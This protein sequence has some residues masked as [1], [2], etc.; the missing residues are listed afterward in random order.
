MDSKARGNS[1]IA[2]NNY[3]LNVKMH[4]RFD[5]EVVDSLTGKVKETAQAENVICAALW[6][7]M[8]TPTTFFYYIHYGTGSGTPATTDTSLFTFL[9][10]IYI[11][12]TNDQYKY[13]SVNGVLSLTRKVQI[14][15]SVAV[16]STITEI[17]IAYGSSANNLCTHAMIKDMNGNQI[18]IAKTSTDII[19]VYATIFA[20]I[21]ATGYDNGKLKFTITNN[22]KYF[23]KG[24]N[25]FSWLL[26]GD[27]AGGNRGVLLND[28]GGNSGIALDSS[29]GRTLSGATTTYDATNKKCIITM[30]RLAADKMN[31][32]SG[33]M[34]LQVV[35]SY[36]TG[37]ITRY[38]PVIRLDTEGSWYPETVIQGEAV[39]TGDGITTDFATKFNYAENATVYVNG[40]ADSNVSVQ[41]IPHKIVTPELGFDAISFESVTGSGYISPRIHI[42]YMNSNDGTVSRLESQSIYYNRLYEYGISKFSL[43]GAIVECSDDQV[44]WTEIARNNS[45]SWIVVTVPEVNRHSKYWRLTSIFER[46]YYDIDGMIFATAPPTTNIHFSV[47]PASG[48]VITADYHTPVIAKDVN[49]VFDLTVT[50]TLGEYTGA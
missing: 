49:H 26:R 34:N 16:G 4:N 46:Q 7:K 39:G 13:D 12:G 36:Y 22:F 35:D 15:E 20:H 28:L 8:F 33:F 11:D 29:S 2:R 9:G 17:G 19:N 14:L 44:T 43:F 47:A 32:F 38:A 18:S 21:P 42:P 31:N 37:S 10:S 40:V 24:P 27:I 48:A 45:N 3:D 5:I 30:S 23:Y 25:L 6:T 41:K 1:R 50:L